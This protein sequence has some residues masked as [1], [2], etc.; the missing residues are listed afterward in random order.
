MIGENAQMLPTTDELSDL[1]Y[2]KKIKNKVENSKSFEYRDQF[3]IKHDSTLI[4]FPAKKEKVPIASSRTSRVPVNPPIRKTLAGRSRFNRNQNVVEPP[5]KLVNDG[6]DQPTTPK[7]ITV[8]QLL[9]R[10]PGEPV[11]EKLVRTQIV[12]IPHIATLKMT[13]SNFERPEVNENPELMK[14]FNIGERNTEILSD[15]DFLKTFH[16]NLK[17][18]TGGFSFSELQQYSRQLGLQ[19]TGRS[20][21]ALISE[22]EKMMDQLGVK[23][24]KQ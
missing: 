15:P 9:P 19:A 6:L 18:E 3:A 16:K 2:G 20:K 12:N 23:N 21:S 14:P 5:Y 22:I 11:P 1:I 24:L 8:E 17:S 7:Q 4:L 10:Y 13:K